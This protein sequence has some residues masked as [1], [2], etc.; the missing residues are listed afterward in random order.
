MWTC[1][2]PRW[3]I[4]LSTAQTDPRNGLQANKKDVDE[5]KKNRLEAP[6]VSRL[7][8]TQSKIESLSAGLKQVTSNTVTAKSHI[9][10]HKH[11]NRAKPIIGMYMCTKKFWTKI[12]RKSKKKSYPVSS[13]DL[14]Y[15]FQNIFAQKKLRKNWRLL[16]KIVLLKK[17]GIMTFVCFLRKNA[18]FFAENR[19]KSQKIVLITS[20]PDCRVE[21]WHRR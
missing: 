4:C 17:I 14:F 8:L 15:N 13:R 3:R 5:A 7:S 12:T 9:S 11:Y 2:L 21:P 1:I 16:F 6:L 10:A 20:T 19:Q 18:N